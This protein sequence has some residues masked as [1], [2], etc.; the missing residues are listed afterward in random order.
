M[1][2]FIDLKNGQ[3]KWTKITMLILLEQKYTS[4]F[5]LPTI[6]DSDMKFLNL[7]HHCLIFGENCNLNCKYCSYGL[8]NKN[9]VKKS[10]VELNT[11][12]LID[13]MKMLGKCTFLLSGG[14]PSLYNSMTELLKSLPD[15][16]W[17]VLTNLNI[18]PEWIFNDRIILIITS[19][20]SGVSKNLFFNNVKALIEEEKRVHVK[21]ICHPNDEYRDID[22]FEKLIRENIP[23]SFVPL[24]YTYFFKRKFILD[25]VKNVQNIS[26]L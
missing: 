6:W 1:V 18:I 8:Y 10:F 15:I 19:Y 4:H 23:V 7:N 22:L 26:T 25:L 17:I 3:G 5:I 9:S 11:N 2:F 16:K 21:I 14:E 20:H 13:F 12:I 24:E